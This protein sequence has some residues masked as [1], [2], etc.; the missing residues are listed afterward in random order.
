MGQP[1]SA[2]LKLAIRQCGFPADEGN[3]STTG[4]GLPFEQLMQAIGLRSREGRGGSLPA[5]TS[6]GAVYLENCHC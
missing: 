4:I 2:E 1:I 3:R 6:R 5:R